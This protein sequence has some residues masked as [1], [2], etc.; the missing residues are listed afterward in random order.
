MCQQFLYFPCSGL[1][2]PGKPEMTSLSHQSRFARF[3]WTE[4]ACKKWSS[5]VLTHSLLSLSLSIYLSISLSFSLSLSLSL[6]IAQIFLT[7]D[8]DI[9]S[10]AECLPWMFLIMNTS[11]FSV[12]PCDHMYH[13][14]FMALL[15]VRNVKWS[16]FFDEH[17][18]M[19]GVCVLVPFSALFACCGHWDR[20]SLSWLFGHILLFL[21]HRREKAERNLVKKPRKNFQRESWSGLPP[22]LGACIGFL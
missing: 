3:L 20:I 13:W 17:V 7:L 16:F 10:L 5:V 12:L 22:N 18:S 15:F 9:N 14:V 2:C 4:L 21:H 19:G 11:I 1:P 6:F 8:R